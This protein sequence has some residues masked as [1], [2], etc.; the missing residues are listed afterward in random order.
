M[1]KLRENTDELISDGARN[2]STWEAAAGS[3]GVDGGCVVGMEALMSVP[4][5]EKMSEYFKREIEA[6]KNRLVRR[7][8][9][10][11]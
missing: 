8:L 3:D 4:N 6:C 1:A 7:G 11:G 5:V 9:K 10:K 2:D